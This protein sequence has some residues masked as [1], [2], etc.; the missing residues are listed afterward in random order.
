MFLLKK[1]N[2]TAKTAHNMVKLCKCTNKLVGDY[3]PF[4]FFE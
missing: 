3:L 2:L 1:K 4:F